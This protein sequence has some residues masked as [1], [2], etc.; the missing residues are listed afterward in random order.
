MVAVDQDLRVCW[1]D[2]GLL[3]Q[4]TIGR[5]SRPGACSV[6][7]EQ[8]ESY[9]YRVRTFYT[10]GLLSV[11]PPKRGLRLRHRNYSREGPLLRRPTDC[12]VSVW[13]W[14]Q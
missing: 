1:I 3:T 7:A 10:R 2:L 13:A 11:T 5:R 9:T 4:P 8:L 6:A 12:S 14:P